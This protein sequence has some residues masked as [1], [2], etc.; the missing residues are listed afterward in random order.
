MPRLVL[1]AVIVISLITLAAAI[2]FGAFNPSYLSQASAQTNP[3]TY[4]VSPTGSDTNSGTSE[5]SPLATFNK[6]WTV[7]K[8]GDTL[9]LLDGVYYQQFRPTVAGTAQAPITIKA[10][11]DGKATID[12]E[13]KY[14]AFV[15]PTDHTFPSPDAYYVIEGINARN[16][17][18]ATFEI[19]KSHVTLRRIHAYNTAEDWD[20]VQAGG[21]GFEAQHPIHVSRGSN[22][23]I[24]D[25][26]TSGSGS[27]MLKVI[28]AQ[29]VTVRRCITDW[30]WMEAHTDHNLWPWSG[31]LNVYHTYQDTFENIISVRNIASQYGINFH[32][33]ERDDHPDPVDGNKYLGSVIIGTGYTPDGQLYDW[34]PIRP[35]PNTANQLDN[36]FDF[37]GWGGMRPGFAIGD[38]IKDTLWQDILVYGNAGL[39]FDRSDRTTISTNNRIVNATFV[40]NGLA[41]NTY[42]GGVGSEVDFRDW[43]A[44]MSITGSFIEGDSNH[45]G[46][47][48]DIRYKYVDG[49]KTNESLWPWPLEQ[50]VRDELGYS[51]TNMVA[52]VTEDLYNKGHLSYKVDRVADIPRPVLGTDKT[53]LPFVKTTIGSSSV[54]TLTVRN[55]GDGDLIVSNIKIT[56]DFKPE[57]FSL[58]TTGTCPTAY[59]F[60]I[61]ANS[62]CTIDV[63]FSPSS[64]IFYPG[65]IKIFPGNLGAVGHPHIVSVLGVGHPTTSTVTLPGRVEAEYYT[66]GYDTTA[67]VI[68]TN[69][70][71]F[72]Q[73]VDV[74]ATIDSGNYGLK[75]GITSTG[76]WLE[77]PVSVSQ[78]GPYIIVAR[79]SSTDTTRS[80]Q[81][82]VLLDGQVI[83]TFNPPYTGGWN[84][85]TDTTLNNISLPSGSHTLR[86]SFDSGYFDLNYLDFLSETPPSADL[87]N[88]NLV[89]STDAAILFNNWF[90]PA[91]SS[92]DI[93]SDTK[94]NGLDFSYLKRDW[95]P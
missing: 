41:A 95:K 49:V 4:Y 46:P 65:R 62:S 36:T 23:L 45:T 58:A 55:S 91:T 43:G 15:F 24:E 47:G 64:L 25:C 21:T 44:D 87:N 90:N 66:N 72:D 20:V 26:I 92:A 70:P 6:V 8:P 86:I 16:G 9:I 74:R 2:Y 78:S 39:A 10:K 48:A 34:G 94:V 7:I 38:G 56:N 76:E 28:R 83:A 22:I 37:T 80:K 68:R 81:F 17:M 84:T 73:G 13:F 88:D 3:Q 71:G 89:N 11:N 82:K 51:V 75:V 30:R 52:E 31:G 67:N 33:V 59:P 42:N 18:Y 79:T 57:A 63:L 1:V 93:Y 29:N 14:N 19:Q 69:L 50:R 85:F 32:G 5:T 61:S 60:T 53:Y 27:K 77:Y 54:Q 35:Q 40:N 12:A